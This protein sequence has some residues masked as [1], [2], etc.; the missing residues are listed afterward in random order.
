MMNG[1]HPIFVQYRIVV[2][3]MPIFDLSRVRRPEILELLG[4]IKTQREEALGLFLRQ[5]GSQGR[6]F[7]KLW[8]KVVRINQSW[9]RQEEMKDKLD[10]DERLFLAQM[11]RFSVEHRTRTLLAQDGDQDVEVTTVDA[12][13][14]PAEW[15]PPPGSDPNRIL[16]YIH[17]GGFIL[18]S[19][20]SVRHLTIAIGQHTGRRVLSLDYRLAPEHPF[21]AAVDDVCAAYGWLLDQGIES[22]DVVV[23]GESAGAYLA[24]MLLLQARDRGWPLPAGS[25]CLAPVTDLAYTGQSYYTNAVTDPV[26]ADVGV[27]W[28]GDAFLSGQPND[29]PETSPF[30]A[31]LEGLPPL[32]IQASTSEMLYDDARAFSEKAQ[33]SGV[34]VTFQTWD[35]TLHAFHYFLELPET[36]EALGKIAAFTARLDSGRPTT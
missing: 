14:V 17:G 18:G 10:S 33:A 28:W 24:L 34:D 16:L 8:S 36:Q 9:F 30:Y 11:H 2:S 32:L 19:P 22:K 5:A 12:G 31:N 13:G 25:V 26:L 20:N 23:A 29:R 7:A 6:D 1:R 27:F 35:H 21:P 4:R 15:Q 3:P